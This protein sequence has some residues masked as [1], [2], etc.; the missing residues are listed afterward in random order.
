[1]A[2]CLNPHCAHPQNPDDAK[3]CL[4]CGQE[5]VPL[6]RNHYKIIKLLGQGGFGRTYLAQDVDKLDQPCVVKQL[7]PHNQGTWANKKSIELFKQEA[8]QLQ[9]LGEHPHIPSLYAYFEQDGYLYLVQQFIQGQDL[10]KELHERGVWQESQIKQLLL[11]LLP[12]LQFIHEK[13]IVHRDIKPENIMRRHL[14]TK[15]GRSGDLVL[16]DFGVSKQLSN[17]VVTVKQGTLIGSQGYGAMEQMKGGK[18]YP[19]SDL[20][21]LGATC[22]HLL[23]NTHPYQL[24]VEEGY[25]WTRNWRNHLPNT[26]SDDLGKVIDRLLHKNLSIRYQSA[27]EV[28]QD[29][30]TPAIASQTPTIPIASVASKTSVQPVSAA[31]KFDR[32]LITWITVVFIGFAGYKYIGFQPSNGNQ[33]N[34]VNSPSPEKPFEPAVSVEKLANPWEKATLVETITGHSDTITS[35]A[36]NHKNNILASGS[37]DDTIKLWDLKTNKEIATLA[38]HADVFFSSVS[39]VVFSH[40]DKILASSSGDGT[41]KLWNVKNKSE[42]ATLTGHGNGASAVVFSH[43]GKTLVSSDGDGKIKLWDVKTQA[44]IF[45]LQ[46]HSDAISSIAFSD[47]SK[48]LASGSNDGVIKLWDVETQEEIANLQGHSDS[49]S[50]LVFSGDGETLASS[51]GD[52]TIKLWNM[53]TKE[54]IVT[55]TGHSDGIASVDFS[56]DSKTLASGSEDNTIKVWDVETQEEIVTLAGHSSNVSSVAFSHDGQ[57]LA[58]GSEDHTIKIWQAQ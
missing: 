50:S 35:V 34:T 33:V 20:F 39:A 38:G 44:E 11:E 21:S 7:T 6:F 49:I 46:G 43:D 54:E 53:E 8:Q 27:Q 3:F 26:I 16:I 15:S 47:D 41:I 4:N 17:K 36:F 58:S 56:H 24:S 30:Q 5:I 28:I 55:L 10:S 12:V 40:D 1:M 2:C 51:S 32:R 14:S 52:G 25:S 45:T 37:G 18:A 9:Q 13:G 19:A 48:T 57:T 29:L 22:F 42:I 31:L 23:T